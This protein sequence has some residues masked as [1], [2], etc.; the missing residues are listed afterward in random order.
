MDRS[1]TSLG[2]T[3]T[4]DA[5]LIPL[6]GW[7][8]AL[9]KQW[10]LDR[11]D[12][13][14]LS[15][16]LCGDEQ[17][18]SVEII[19]SAVN[20]AEQVRADDTLK[21]RFAKYDE[22]EL[23]QALD[24]NELDSVFTQAVRKHLHLYGDRGLQ[25]LKVEQPSL[26]D[27]PWVLMKMIRQY[28]AQNVTVASYRQ[29]EL[30]VRENADRKLAKLL[31]DQPWKFKLLNDV[32]LPRLR[33]L[34]RHRE[35]SRYCRSELFGFSKQ[36]FKALAEYLVQR[37]VLRETGDIVH[38]TQDEI[39]GY[40]NGMGV[41][42]NLQALADLRRTEFEQ[43]N[44]AEPAEQITTLGAV[45]DNDLCPA[46]LPDLSD[47]A[48]VGLGSSA[49]KVRGIARVVHDPNTMDSTD[50][51]MIL[52]ARETDPGWL[53]LMLASKGMVVERGSMLSHTA[54][55]G[56]KFGIPT[57]VALP[58]ATKLIPDGALIEIDGSSG[59]V[60]LIE[61]SGTHA[62]ADDGKGEGAAA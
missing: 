62:S 21:K 57:I 9:F 42:E 47:N 56:R 12:P 17:L 6:Y 45:R 19:L 34:I 39:F 3:L 35:N 60:T 18:L 28:A 49:G 37:G 51:N 40:I 33:R 52:I 31:V 10:E 58:N 5:Y 22:H 7:T 11:D 24:N 44:A 15:D 16:L 48:L 14:L 29:H 41:T 8:E 36:T 25:E 4:T 61:E 38:L 55:T 30:D 1:G 26:R 54:I 32:I 13:G 23:W 43:F 46:E 50:E 59:V 2:V 27:T 53:F 20:L